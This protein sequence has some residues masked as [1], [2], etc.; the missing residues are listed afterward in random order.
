MRD[1]DKAGKLFQ[2]CLCTSRTVENFD[3]W[4]SVKALNAIVMSDPNVNIFTPTDMCKGI[5]KLYL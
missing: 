5:P 3:N 1:N 4:A 2:L